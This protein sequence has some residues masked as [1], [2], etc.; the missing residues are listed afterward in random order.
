[1]CESVVC[2]LH[3]GLHS[4]FKHTNELYYRN[5]LLDE[6]IQKTNNK[7]VYICIGGMICCISKLYNLNLMFRHYFALLMTI[8][9][10]LNLLFGTASL[11]SSVH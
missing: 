6:S 10:Y 5:L 3:Y 1:M 7:Y 8:T 2:G 4:I 11:S 9:E